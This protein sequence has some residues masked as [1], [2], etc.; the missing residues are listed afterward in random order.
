MYRPG[1][2]GGYTGKRERRRDGTTHAWGNAEAGSS[3]AL[4]RVEGRAGIAIGQGLRRPCADAC[5][6]QGKK[7]DEQKRD[8][9]AV[10]VRGLNDCLDE[11]THGACT[12]VISRSATD[13]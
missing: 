4:R 12:V 11:I 13:C 9:A 10:S 8:T 2:A 3:V 1:I 5:D 6:D 7:G